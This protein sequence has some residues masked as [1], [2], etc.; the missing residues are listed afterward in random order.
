V[1]DKSLKTRRHN[2]ARELKRVEFVRELAIIRGADECKTAFILWARGTSLDVSGIWGDG[3]VFRP[4]ICA[5]AAWQAAWRLNPAAP[6]AP[7]TSNN[8]VMK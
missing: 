5:W 4:A 7:P 2:A 3:P 1:K 6:A 8:E